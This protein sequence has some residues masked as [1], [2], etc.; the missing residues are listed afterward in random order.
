M[1][2]KHI[3]TS[4]LLCAL[5]FVAFSSFS[6][7][8]ELKYEVGTSASISSKSSLPF[9][10]VS[11]KNGIIPDENNGLLHLTL[12]SNFNK[13]DSKF[14]FSYKA[15]IVGS[16]ANKS[17]LFFDEFYTSLKWKKF[18]ADIGLK[19]REIK[20]DGLSV[21]NGDLLISGNAR[22]YPEISIGINEFLPLGFTNNWVAIKGVFANGI[23]LDDRYVDRANVHHKNAFLRI[24]KE[25]GLSFSIGLDHY[26]QWGGTSP[27]WG[28][29][30]GFR[31]FKEAVFVQAGKVLIDPDGNESITDSYNKSGNHIGQNTFEFAY[32]NDQFQSILSFKNIYEDK[33]GDFLHI[34]R[35]ND[36]NA[37]LFIKLNDSKFISSFIYEYFYTKHQGGYSIRPEH[38]IEPIIG[39]DNYFSNGVFRSG[40]TNH[41]RTIG[42]PL[43]TPGF[44]NALVAHHFGFKGAVGNFKYRALITLSENYGTP[45]LINDGKGNQE[46]NYSKSYSFGK[47]KAQQSY[48][49]ELTFPKI[50]K[51][52]LLI[53]T[54][55]AMDTGEYLPDNIGFQ[56]NLTYRGIFSK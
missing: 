17:E 47:S 19:H 21:T 24:G 53:S 50:N 32:S 11:N 18:T 28:N 7:K 27:K 5:L 55:V 56:L 10:L 9:W 43:I 42:L 16:Q 39:F 25:K 36:W 37:S 51:F 23:L 49:L 44:N 54:C 34:N 41:Q 29:L 35:V 15:S 1:N 46:K 30:G 48:K 13:T 8:K 2:F 12:F 3:T 38:P 14:D 31:A 26:V 33:S 52:P 40:W 22:S 6:Q 4:T 45:K 20:Y